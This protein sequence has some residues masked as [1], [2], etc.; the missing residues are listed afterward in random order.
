MFVYALDRDGR[1]YDASDWT[2]IK[3]SN[4]IWTKT[5][6]MQ[7]GGESVANAKEYAD[8]FWNR[9]KYTVSTKD[10]I[11]AQIMNA[12]TIYDVNKVILGKDYGQG[13]SSTYDPILEKGL[14]S[15]NTA[16]LIS[17]L[18]TA[19]KYL[20]HSKDYDSAKIAELKS[21]RDKVAKGFAGKSYTQVQVDSWTSQLATA[22][23]GLLGYS[24]TKVKGIV[25]TKSADSLNKSYVELY[26]INGKKI[27]NRG[28]QP[29]TAWAFD[30]K[31]TNN[32]NGSVYYRVAIN[33]Y[34]NEK[35]VTVRNGNSVGNL[36]NIEK[37][38]GVLNV[39]KSQAGYSLY[40][41]DGSLV[42][43][44]A[45]AGGTNWVVSAKASSA[46]GNLFYK[47]A[48][49]EWVMSGNGVSFN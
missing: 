35:D 8:H 39:D 46:N 33:E 37:V 12:K 19:D 22:N 45:L 9:V 5:A 14:L 24:E 3:P 16:E 6:I 48:K 28:L 38:K 11:T 36:T 21:V 43:N 49:N 27:S 34:V 4:L 23:N 30:R 13:I 42:G 44:R 40:K 15:I 10:D 2:H 32:K 29:K 20:E 18:N 26:D 7:S 1:T 17:Q 31:L 25:D 41:Q 47:V